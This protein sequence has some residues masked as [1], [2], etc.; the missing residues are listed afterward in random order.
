MGGS[1]E[2]KVSARHLQGR[3]KM[4]AATFKRPAFG[5]AVEQKPPIHL[6][7]HIGK[8]GSS[9]PID[10]FRLMVIGFVAKHSDHRSEPAGNGGLNCD[11]SC[12]VRPER[13]GG[14]ESRFSGGGPSCTAGTIQFTADLGLDRLGGPLGRPVLE[15]LP[16]GGR[17]G[18][19]DSRAA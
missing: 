1:T 12:A 10:F 9:N 3:E 18:I 7:C 14:I 17:R 15:V 8:S 6:R 2:R 4:K 11:G 16:Y 19:T 13:R 5:S